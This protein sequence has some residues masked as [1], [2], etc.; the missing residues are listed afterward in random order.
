MTMISR[1]HPGTAFVQWF[2]NIPVELRKNLAHIFR[3]CTTE[4]T[5]Q[6]AALPE[7]SLAGFMAW[8][9]KPDFPLR[10]AAKMFYIRAVFDM[11]ILHH[12]E[13]TT[14][15]GAF[16][17]LSRQNNIVQLSS[18]QWKTVI[19]SWRNLRREEL[20]DGYLHSWTSWM[21]QQQKESK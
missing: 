18:R 14:D 8:A 2:G 12:D 3:V 15:G 13:I 20:S 21:I 9:V 4:D 7:Q 5:A 17:P 16:G 11:V 10:S 19:D 1:I 6:M